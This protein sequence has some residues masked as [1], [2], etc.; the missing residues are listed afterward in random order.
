MRPKC[1]ETDILLTIA[2]SKLRVELLILRYTRGTDS[3]LLIVGVAKMKILNRKLATVVDTENLR[4]LIAEDEREIYRANSD[5]R[6]DW[7][8]S[9][10][11][12]L[13]KH[14]NTKKK[15][16]RRVSTQGL[17]NS[18]VDNLVRLRG[19]H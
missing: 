17:T 14:N 6:N 5:A 1:G 3:S 16:N 11:N 7:Q 19:Q 9:L 8:N 10:L 12:K 15:V 2:V 13:S 18:Y 4:S